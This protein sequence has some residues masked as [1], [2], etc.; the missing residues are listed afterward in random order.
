[1]KS[2]AAALAASILATGAWAEGAIR[3]VAIHVNQNDPAV[4]NMAL[5]ISVP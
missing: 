5:V 3:H 1:M 4:M 2:A